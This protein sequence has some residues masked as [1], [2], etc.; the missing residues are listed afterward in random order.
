MYHIV[1]MRG[2]G[3]R[4]A[5]EQRM[6]SISA[7]TILICYVYMLAS[8]IVAGNVLSKGMILLRRAAVSC[9]V[10]SLGH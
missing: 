5:K 3:G 1:G 9:K 7:V 6:L 8:E 2:A 10:Q 4:G